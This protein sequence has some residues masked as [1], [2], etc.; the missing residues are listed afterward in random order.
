MNHLQ[1]AAPPSVLVPAL[2]I[3]LGA[4]WLGL[5]NWRRS[6][7]NRAVG[8]L[9]ALRFL[10]VTMLLFTLLRPEYV[11][12]LQR[13]TAP[14]IAILMDASDSMKTRDLTLTN[15]VVSRAQWL[16]ARRAAKFWLPLESQAKVAVEDFAVPSTNAGAING[17]DLNAAL[18]L[19][20]QRFKNL[21]AVLVLSDGDWNMGK[22]PLATATRY[23]EQNI[24]I[25]TVAV[26]RLTPLPD[27]ILENVSMPAYGLLG[28]DIAVPFK[29]TS[30]L[31]REVK[32][33]VS[34]YD[35]QGEQAKKE[36]TIP[37]N[38]AVEDAVLWSPRAAG[39]ITATVKVPVEPEES[40]AENN[41][42]SFHI[43][44]RQEKL[45]VLVVDSL[46]RWEYRYLRNALARD[47]GVDMQCLLYHPEIGPGGGPNYI[48]AFPA[49]KEALAPYD[50]IFL[51]DVGIG[52]NELTETNAAMIR[53]LVEQQ[54][55]GLVFVPGPRG[56]EATFLDSP[57][58]DLYPGRVG[59]IQTAGRRTGERG[60]T[61]PDQRRQT[62]LA[63][64]L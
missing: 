30:H 41:E 7:R 15:K 32:T 9:E 29:V 63:H 16:D 45:K 24:P 57:L 20:L 8:R 31:A 39:E 34:I 1:L 42:R 12:H 46:P 36:I 48:P 38:G 47:P 4:G 40:I 49:T 58:A 53:G 6:A 25:F 23:R 33:T 27:L 43:S 2:A 10:L 62:S 55:S 5:A 19:T 56:R 50:V 35:P 59:P 22:S 61:G 3:W 28:E 13:K 14:E 17:T 44:I 52:Q 18:E 11:E 60:A 26:G 54:A 21:K 51:G 64:P 37:P